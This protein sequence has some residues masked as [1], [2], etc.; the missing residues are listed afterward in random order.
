MTRDSSGISSRLGREIWMLLEVRRKTKCPFLAAT[1]I[2]RFLLIFQNSQASSYRSIELRVPLKVSKGCAAPVKMRQGH[3]AFCRASTG[4]SDIPSSCEK[5]DKPSF[6]PL[7]G[8]PAFFRVRAS[9]CPFR[10][11][12]QTQRPLTYVLL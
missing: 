6:K 9:W 1:V 11:T 7:Q 2:L 3:G 10:L 4:D 12:Q 5:N 8:N